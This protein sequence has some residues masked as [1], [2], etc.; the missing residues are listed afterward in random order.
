M[1]ANTR[2][3]RAARRGGVLALILFLLALPARAD[4]PQHAERIVSTNL[5]ADQL[6]LVLAPARVVSV[7]WVASDSG[8]S[9]VAPL[10]HALSRNDAELEEV[11]SY[12]PDLVLTDAFAGEALAQRLEALSVR[13]HRVG[14]AGSVSAAIAILREAAGALDAVPQGEGLIAAMS[15]K[16]ALAQ[17]AGTFGPRTRVLLLRPAGHTAAGDTLAAELLALAGLSDMA[18]AAGLPAG[19]ELSLEEIVM[20]APPVLLLDAPDALGE[21]RAESLL[22]HPALQRMAQKP[23]IH[24]IPTRLWIC[25]GPWLGDAALALTRARR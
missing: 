1:V 5:C 13:V 2:Q 4:A 20:L 11:L 22:S 16:L 3:H 10:A 8:I 12:A 19:R 9:N 6:A 23:I 24:L 21:S 14:W 15:A 17:A 25:P 18:L 7:S